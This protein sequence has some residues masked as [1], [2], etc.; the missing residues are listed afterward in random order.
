MAMTRVDLHYYPTASAVT[1]LGA[2]RA[3]RAGAAEAA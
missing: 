1:G 3:G 2:A